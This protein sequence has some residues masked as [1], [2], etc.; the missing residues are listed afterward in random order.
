[1]YSI[2]VGTSVGTIMMAN[3]AAFIVLGVTTVVFRPV[4]ATCTNSG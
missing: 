1:M 4:M 3:F 2:F